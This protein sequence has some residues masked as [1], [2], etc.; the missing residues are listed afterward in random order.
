MSPPPGG[1][2]R[3]TATPASA[4]WSTRRVRLRSG[5]SRVQGSRRRD[6]RSRSAGVGD[7]WHRVVVSEVVLH[8]QVGAEI[9]GRVTPHAVD[10]VGVVLG[11]VELDEGDRALDA[12]GMWLVDGGAAG[13]GELK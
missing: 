13:P 8:E 3:H 10:M 1:Q 12:E 7:G 4:P 5:I 9:V 6:R 2:Q 11:V